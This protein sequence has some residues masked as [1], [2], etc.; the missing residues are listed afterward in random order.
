MECMSINT[1]KRICY[2]RL[3]GDKLIE[4]KNTDNT[5]QILDHAESFYM[6]E[7]YSNVKI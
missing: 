1:D 7:K 3:P 2:S 5:K 6:H 4:R